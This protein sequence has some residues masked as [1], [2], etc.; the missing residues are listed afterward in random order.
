MLS[1]PTA[2]SGLLRVV[3]RWQIVALAVNGVIGSGIYLLPASTAALLGPASV[4]AVLLAGLTV[5]LLVLCFAQA[6]SYFDQA[7]GAYLYTR[8][9]F[10]EFVGFQIGWMTWL[11]RVVSVAALAAGL[12]QALGQLSPALT[13]A[14]AAA[15]IA[16]L[17]IALVTA[18]NWIGVQSGA[19]FGVVLVLVKLLPLALLIGVGAFHLDPSALRVEH[20]PA[21]SSFA[22]AAL[23]LLFAYG[24]FENAPAAAAEYRQ[25]QRD[26][27]F[28]LVATILIVT[29]VY[30]SIQAV[31]L[32]LLPGL[33]QSKAP[34]AEAAERLGGA[35]AVWLLT[36][37]AAV[38]ILGTMGSSTLFGPRYLYALAADGYGPRPLAEVHP[39]WHTPHR[40][41]AVQGT[42]AL[43]LALTGSFV[44]LAL[45]SVI[46][47]L[48]TYIGTAAALLV[49][50]PRY[51]HQP[52]ALRLPGGRLIAALALLI[53]LGL[54]ASAD[55][56]HLGAGVVAVVLG[57]LVYAAR[58]RPPRS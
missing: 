41:L 6:S 16:T 34:L 25:P 43:L 54:L 13:G 28:A 39:R 47:R 15:L 50:I 52:E 26:L 20:W 18:V 48:C 3:S 22:A 1:P 51:Q 21:P 33:A 40:A 9:A 35:P 8:E 5:A 24:G 42:L 2:S 46:A 12:A 31:A 45:L 11:S 14:L 58:R 27:P 57:S 37:G 56:R 29:L 38:S 23:L 30:V 53:S 55:A 4:W 7:G 17:G 19:R 36:V 44:E 10:G 32:G 49:L